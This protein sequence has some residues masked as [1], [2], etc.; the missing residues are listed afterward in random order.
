MAC[1]VHSVTTHQTKTMHARNHSFGFI[2]LVFV[3]AGFKLFR[4]PVILFDDVA[5]VR[6]TIPRC[7][8]ICW[9]YVRLRVLVPYVRQCSKQY[10]LK[11]FHEPGTCARCGKYRR[12][13]MILYIQYIRHEPYYSKLFRPQSF[14]HGS[15]CAANL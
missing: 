7:S 5:H 15:S 6:N 2:S 10:I 14:H 8:A 3:H 9:R 4:F 11:E 12:Q 13:L 1:R